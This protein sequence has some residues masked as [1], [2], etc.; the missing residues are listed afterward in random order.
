MKNSILFLKS[1]SG[2]WLTTIYNMTLTKRLDSAEYTLAETSFNGVDCYVLTAKYPKLKNA[3]DSVPF[4]H[5]FLFDEVQQF[6]DAQFKTANTAELLTEDEW[7]FPAG[8]IAENITALRKGYYAAISLTIDK[9]SA[10]PAIYRIMYFDE[11]GT[12][13]DDRRFGKVTA[14]KKPSGVFQTVEIADVAVSDSEN[15]GSDY[16]TYHKP[17][18]DEPKSFTVSK[19]INYLYVLLAVAGVIFLILLIVKM[20]KKAK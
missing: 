13:I 10:S 14:M 6:F 12:L 20:A 8:F 5:I 2:S 15:F 19:Y 9:N 4:N 18:V 11:K 1:S 16:A 3:A 17:Q 7:F